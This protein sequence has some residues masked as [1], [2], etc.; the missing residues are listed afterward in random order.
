ME[1]LYHLLIALTFKKLD[2]PKLQKMLKNVMNIE[3]KKYQQLK[4]ES[5]NHIKDLDTGAVDVDNKTF[6]GG[7]HHLLHWFNS[8]RY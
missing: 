3:V 6:E 5:R 4:K 8:L 1:I 7:C 2:N